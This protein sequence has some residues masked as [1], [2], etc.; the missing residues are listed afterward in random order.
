MK[1]PFKISLKANEKIYVNGAVLRF[2]RRTSIE[3]LND[4]N[5][6]L[7]GHVMQIEQAVSPI[8]QLY[9]VIQIMLMAPNNIEMSMAV[10]KQQ[11]QAVRNHHESNSMNI[12][13]LQ[14]DDLVKG[15]KYY[16]AMK[17]IRQSGDLIIGK[18]KIENKNDI[19]SLNTR[20]LVY[21]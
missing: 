15:S 20:S 1:N 8:Q 11:I 10:Y 6:L 9:Y 4:V 19:I 13:L 7:E 2:D 16:E 21:S 14:I 17:I 3:F 18:Q 5:F 12:D